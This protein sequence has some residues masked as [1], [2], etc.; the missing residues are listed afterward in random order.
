VRQ[1]GL[2]DGAVVVKSLVWE[3]YERRPEGGDGLMRRPLVVVLRLN[4]RVDEK[5]LAAALGNGRMEEEVGV[6]VWLMGAEAAENVSGFEMG[7][8]PP[9]GHSRRMRTVVDEELW[10]ST[11]A[12]QGG[13]DNDAVVFGG[14]GS[15]G[16][17]LRIRLGDLVR[18]GGATVAAIS[19]PFNEQRS[20][21]V[22]RDETRF[23]AGQAKGVEKEAMSRASSTSS[24]YS[25]AE[26]D[27]GFPTGAALRKAATKAD[28]AEEVQALLERCEMLGGVGDEVTAILN[29]GTDASGKTALHLA[30]W[31]GSVETVRLLL[32]AGANIDAYSTGQ[33]NYGKTALFYALTRCRD[34]MVTLLVQR[35]ADVL[36][37]NNKGQV[38]TRTTT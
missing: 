21:K 29:S 4:R 35:G 38:S 36:I 2:P 7:N 16:Y 19:V 13:D 33:G 31:R 18:Y 34:E 23:V 9:L 12:R 5:R 3:Y 30:A 25:R 15:P 8:V 32:N 37:C 6:G 28:G 14:G 27:L 11:M 26:V 10:S 20:R 17:E 24:R 1:E 22:E